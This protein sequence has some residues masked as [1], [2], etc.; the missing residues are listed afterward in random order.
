M[1]YFVYESMH[2]KLQ[3]VFMG[4]PDVGAEPCDEARQL[5]G[6]ERDVQI[7]SSFIQVKQFVVQ[8]LD[9]V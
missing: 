6:L 1:K 7:K 3:S 4:F 5:P 8:I 9:I 2:L